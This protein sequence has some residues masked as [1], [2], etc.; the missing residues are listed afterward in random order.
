MDYLINQTLIHARYS[1]AADIKSFRKS[2]L[3]TVITDEFE[4]YSRNQHAIKFSLSIDESLAENEQMADPRAIIRALSNLLSNALRFANGKINVSFNENETRYL[5][6]VEDDGQ[7]IEETQ[8]ENIFKPFSQINNDERS[9]GQGHGLGLAIVYQIALWH[10]GQ[11][12]VERSSL[13][14]ARFELCWPCEK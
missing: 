7:G 1:R 6:V 4:Q 10:K 2:N 11:A 9:T 8:T 12:S 13:G 3:A 5:L 14:G